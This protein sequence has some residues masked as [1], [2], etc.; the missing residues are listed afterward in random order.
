MVK[1]EAQDFY[2]FVTANL[3]FLIVALS[4]L[5]ARTSALAAEQ[6]RQLAARIGIPGGNWVRV[7]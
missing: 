2:E 5:W 4:I 6:Y 3:L 1:K 7:G